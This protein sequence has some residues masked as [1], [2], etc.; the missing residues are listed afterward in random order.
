MV[1]V[2]VQHSI[3]VEVPMELPTGCP[4]CHTW[5]ENED[6]NNLLVYRSVMVQGKTSLVMGSGTLAEVLDGYDE[7]SDD[8][9]A[10]VGFGCN[11]CKKPIIHPHS[12]TWTLKD[13]LS[14][15][16]AQLQTLLYDSN[17]RDPFIRQKVFGPHTDS[18]YQGDCEACNIEARIGTREV[19]H[20]IDARLH[21]CK[22]Q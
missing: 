17:V 14:D 11:Y 9:G 20:P 19:P 18:G 10:I 4:H 16:A 13:M 3:L 6:E 8:H 21:T 12:R 1:R 5:L 22:R 7:V 2:L 15:R